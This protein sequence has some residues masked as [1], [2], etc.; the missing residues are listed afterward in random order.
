M[1]LDLED[2]KITTSIT[3]QVYLG[4]SYLD[5]QADVLNNVS[6]VILL[7]NGFFC[8][9]GKLE[10][11]SHGFVVGDY[12]YL[13]QNTPGAV[14]NVVPTSGISQRL[15]FV[16]D[17]NILHIDIERAIDLDNPLN[18]TATKLDLFEYRDIWAE[19]SAATTAGSAEWSFGNGA[20]GF[21]GLPI[22]AG[23]EVEAMYFHADSYSA[24]GTIQVDLMNYGNTPSNA[25]AN[26]ITSI[27]LANST[28]GGGTTNNGYKYEV[29]ATPIQ[30]PVTGTSTV[31][32]F[33]TRGKTGTVSDARVGAR[34]RR[35]IGEYVS[36][37]TLA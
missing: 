1:S 21:M 8:E 26:T 15:F 36:D 34:L 10:F 37:I 6:D 20:V 22:D 25:A 2:I 18:V 7:D 3:P 13:D 19:E 4:A 28:D 9:S 32:G 31:I 35:K 29:L 24:T 16:E 12:Y 27:S 5:A 23:W 11:P 14:T 17:P 33:I 30:I